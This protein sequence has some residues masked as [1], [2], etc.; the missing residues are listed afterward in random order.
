M[1]SSLQESYYSSGRAGIVVSPVASSYRPSAFPYAMGTKLEKSI[2]PLAS[3]K[4]ISVPASFRKWYESGLLLPVR[5]QGKCGSCWSFALSGALGDRVCLWTGGKVK[6]QLSAQQFVS[7]DPDEGTCQGTNS[8]PRAIRHISTDNPNGIKGLYPAGNFEYVSGDG[9]SVTDCAEIEATAQA[10]NLM[11]TGY[12]LDTIQNLCEGDDEGLSGQNLE[13]DLLARNVQRM[14]EE[15]MTNGPIIAAMVVYN[16]FSAYQAGTVYEASV[17]SGVAGGHAVEIVGWDN[18][19][20]K[21]CWIIKNSWG[22]K[23]GMAG[24]WYQKI[25]D[26]GSNLERGAHAALPD[27]SAKQFTGI[28]PTAP[29]GVPPQPTPQPNGPVS[30][31]PP[32]GPTPT[33]PTSSKCPPQCP[34]CPSLQCPTG[35]AGLSSAELSKHITAALIAATADTNPLNKVPWWGW[36]IVGVGLFLFILLLLLIAKS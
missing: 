23:W 27:F 3:I 19:S 34:P 2:Y 4:G 8:I 31:T 25:G 6:E 22:P 12:K 1:Y 28:M 15:I 18:I 36:I 17:Q 32:T 21:D 26:D 35:N 13:P 11:K 33:D 7:C 16:D 30:P 24:Y 9:S 14:K 29:G 5:N 20:G 10:K